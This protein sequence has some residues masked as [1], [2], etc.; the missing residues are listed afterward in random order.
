MNGVWLLLAISFVLALAWRAIWTSRNRSRA[1]AI[2]RFVDLALSGEGHVTGITQTAPSRFLVSV[3][4]ATSVFYRPEIL[5]E[6][7]PRHDLLEWL[8]FCLKRRRELLIFQTDLDLAPQFSFEG[9]NERWF[10]RTRRRTS[11]AS[12]N[13]ELETWA[14][15]VISTQSQWKNELASTINNLFSSR[16]HDLLSVRFQRRS[17]HFAAA[18]PVDTLPVTA[19]QRPSFFDSLRAL[20]SEASASRS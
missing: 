18:L 8:R 12:G 14:P 17:P 15:C 20:A 11:L 9:I 10:G 4:L 2:L 13:W 5:L 3:Q 19:D 7:A 1:M 6:L 16:H